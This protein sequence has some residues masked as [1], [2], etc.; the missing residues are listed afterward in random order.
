MK[1]FGFLSKEVEGVTLRGRSLSQP[2]QVP[3]EEMGDLIYRKLALNVE[4][5]ILPSKPP[6][7]W[8]LIAAWKK[9]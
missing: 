6:S 5:G 2:S 9:Y 3:G 1:R 4:N 7:V 8:L